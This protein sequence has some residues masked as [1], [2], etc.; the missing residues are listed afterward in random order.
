MSNTTASGG[1]TG[2]TASESERFTSVASIARRTSC[3]IARTLASAHMRARHERRPSRSRWPSGAPRRERACNVASSSW[4]HTADNYIVRIRARRL[5][6]MRCGHAR[7]RLTLE[8]SGT[9]ATLAT[10]RTNKASGG[11]S[12]SERKTIGGLAPMFRRVWSVG[13]SFWRTSSTGRSRAT[14]LRR[15]GWWHSTRPTRSGGRAGIARGGRVGSSSGT[16]THSC[17]RLTTTRA[18]A[19]S[20]DMWQNTGW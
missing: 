12:R 3:P 10:A 4:R 7:R 8:Q 1:L 18:R 17:T 14:A 16:A 5:D 11:T 2:V 6:T 19:T 20:V 15:V 13:E 9:L